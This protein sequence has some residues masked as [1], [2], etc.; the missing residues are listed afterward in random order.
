MNYL[1]SFIIN[2]NYVTFYTRYKNQK[3]TSYVIIIINFRVVRTLT[4]TI[5]KP[6]CTK[7]NQLKPRN[8]TCAYSVILK[9]N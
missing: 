1:S 4:Y 9:S 3:N 2:S 5:F 7:F 8:T 6:R